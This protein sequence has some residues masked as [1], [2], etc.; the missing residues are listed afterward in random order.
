MKIRLLS[1]FLC[2]CMVLSCMTVL[3]AVSVGGG[4]GGGPFI[5]KY[6]YYEDGGTYYGFFDEYSFYESDG[7]LDIS[8]NV[9]TQD[10][11]M[12]GFGGYAGSFT[13]V[14]GRT[15]NSLSQ[16]EA[17]IP[18][19]I[20]VAVT[21]DELQIGE[22]SYTTGI[23]EI[24]FDATPVTYTA[25]TYSASTG[26]LAGLSAN[27][28]I[29]YCMVD[30]WDG[31]IWYEWHYPYLDEQ[32]YYDLNVYD[33]GI[34][35]TNM[36]A[37]NNQTTL[38]NI[39]TRTTPN[40][41]MLSNIQ[42]TA[43]EDYAITGI[44][45][46]LY[47]ANGNKLQAVDGKEVEWEWIATF[48]DLPADAGIYTIK[49][50]GLRNGSVA[51][52][53]YSYEYEK[54]EVEFQQGTVT[55]IEDD[56][57]NYD[58]IARVYIQE[59][60]KSWDREYYC[61]LPVEVG[62]TV[63]TTTAQLKTAMPVGSYVTI[64]NAG[65][66]CAFRVG[67]ATSAYENYGAISRFQ[68]AY[69]TVEEYVRVELV[70]PD[71]TYETYGIY[72]GAKMG[73]E[74]MNNV[75]DIYDYIKR[76]NGA[77]ATFNQEDGEI[78]HFTIGEEGSYEEKYNQTYSVSSKAFTSLTAAQKKLPLYYNYGGA[79]YPAYLDENHN[80]DLAIFDHGVVI[81]DMSA[82]YMSETVKTIQV[83]V[84]GGSNL[85]Q[86]IGFV[87]N[88]S[89]GTVLAGK[90]YDANGRELQSV[91]GRISGEEG[92][93]IF[94]DLSNVN[95]SYRYLL[96]VE[97]SSGS[98]VSP[99]YES[100]FDVKALPSGSGTITEARVIPG[101][102]DTEETLAV[103]I[104]KDGT[105]E[106]VETATAARFFVDGERYTNT[107]EMAALLPVGTKIE[108]IGDADGNLVAVKRSVQEKLSYG[109]I[110]SYSSTGIDIVTADGTNQRFTLANN[111]WLNGHF[112]NRSNDLESALNSAS[113]WYVAYVASGDEIT[114]LK[115]SS[116]PVTQYTD[117]T[118]NVSGKY[119]NGLHTK[120]KLPIIYM[121]GASMATPVLDSN[122]RYNLNVYEYGVEITG[123]K[124]KDKDGAI[125]HID[126]GTSLNNSFLK[127]VEIE[128]YPTGIQG[129]NV[130]KVQLLDSRGYLQQEYSY[131]IE[132]NN[133]Q[134]VTIPNLP[135][136]DSEYR[137]K[138]WIE[139]AQGERISNTYVHTVK[140]EETDISYGTITDATTGTDENGEACV[141]L[142]VSIPGLDEPVTVTCPLGTV[143]NGIP[144]TSEEDL[145]ELLANG[146]LVKI[147]DDGKR[148]NIQFTD[149][150]QNV[151]DVNVSGDSVS[152]N[153]NMSVKPGTTISGTAYVGVYSKEGII[154]KLTATPFT[155]VAGQPNDPVPVNVE[156]ITYAQGDYLKVVCMDEN[157]RPLCNVMKVDIE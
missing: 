138:M 128:I 155:V 140:V 63:C 90:L 11:G 43:W 121:I 116:L 148:P 120:E 100:K 105:G 34:V 53:I 92:E 86:E 150:I 122:H 101:S 40:G 49:L 21:I 91:T 134:D 124:G 48:T 33:Y 46:E 44:K 144:V 104:R 76:N 20:P 51:T 70:L 25:K 108:Y 31:E 60:D 152:A 77:P 94:A 95:A 82:R 156:G 109:T 143:I 103:R 139:N 23:Y 38:Y 37:K 15:Y 75:D 3:G 114:S 65:Y 154:K 13:K 127:D 56:S 81:T 57:N 59:D 6:E 112:M 119:F 126:A 47:D 45:G 50:W 29:F 130:L 98:I 22:Y 61:V 16:L 123:I 12:H 10:G 73:D 133:L 62:N 72:P 71:G 68:I 142:K 1:T 18:H 141:I 14:N 27:L 78:T 89:G 137:I 107:E 35:I 129:G 7:Y 136:Q 106:I 97:N 135:N 19:N 132:G 149:S 54:E 66:D 146:T 2:L 39:G 118:Y 93:V 80:Y 4:G 8:L 99:Y 67:E 151:T 9:P 113:S 79:F 36:Y 125:T 74:K 69:N 131:P 17:A 84:N 153:I 145:L 96:W 157:S 58:N 41:K 111:V 55:K 115:T 5:P 26:T 32:H 83:N 110:I 24:N 85:K 52:P 42:V 102:W 28:P 147:A 30:N 87:C 117:A 88:V 64:A